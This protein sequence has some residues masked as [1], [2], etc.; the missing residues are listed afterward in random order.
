[1]KTI[2]I[3]LKHGRDKV[4]IT[5]GDIILVERLPIHASSA[6][7]AMH[8]QYKKTVRLI[9]GS[10]VLIRLNGRVMRICE[11]VNGLEFRSKT[12]RF[13]WVVTSYQQD[14][15]EVICPECENEQIVDIDDDTILCDV[16]EHMYFVG[17]EI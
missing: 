13:G 11:G 12:I 3:T 15:K 16:C 10:V 5:D 17:D 4:T 2:T 1:M 6:G 8:R 9:E 7:N 14:T